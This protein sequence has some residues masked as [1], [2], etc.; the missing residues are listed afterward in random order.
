MLNIYTG[1]Q[2]TYTH[3]YT[4][5]HIYIYKQTMNIYTVQLHILRL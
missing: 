4:H 5:A 1:T 3:T 2:Y